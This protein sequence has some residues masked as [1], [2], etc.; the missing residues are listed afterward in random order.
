MILLLLSSE[1]FLRK[2]NHEGC[3][4]FNEEFI[5]SQWEER[6]SEKKLEFSVKH[7]DL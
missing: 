1:L 3:E 6:R 2:G 7:P 4:D 5:G